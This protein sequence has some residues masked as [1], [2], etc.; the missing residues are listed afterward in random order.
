MFH[1]THLEAEQE[2][3]EEGAED[4][5]RDARRNHERDKDETDDCCAPPGN[6]VLVAEPVECHIFWYTSWTLK[7]ATQRA[8]PYVIDFH[9]V[10][11]YPDPQITTM[12]LTYTDRFTAS[13]GTD[14]P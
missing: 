9:G 5:E 11:T 14:T 10:L 7:V 3:L 8:R 1:P 4:D 2:R 13:R 12:T 6:R